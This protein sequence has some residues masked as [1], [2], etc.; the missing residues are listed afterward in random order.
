MSQFAE[1]IYAK[2]T[3]LQVC[4]D[5]CQ[6]ESVEGSSCLYTVTTSVTYLVLVTLAMSAVRISRIL[7]LVNSHCL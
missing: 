7:P 5:T 3:D 6:T 2:P 1:K 4:A